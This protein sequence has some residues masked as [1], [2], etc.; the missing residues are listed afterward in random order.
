VTPPITTTIEGEALMRRSARRLLGAIATVLAATTTTGLITNAPVARATTG[1]FSS[2]HGI[3]VI[4]QQQVDPRRIDLTVS[5]SAAAGE[6]HIK[7]LL[8]SDYAT[9]SAARYP[10]LYLLHGAGD[11]ADA[12]L[13]GSGGGQA[14]AITAGKPLITVIP[15]GG[16]KGWYTNWRNPR[17]SAPQNWETFHVNQL[18]P[19]ID[20]NLRTIADR[21]GRAI[22]GLSM[23]GF[24]AMHYAIDHP[25][26]FAYVASFSGALDLL[27]PVIR[28]TIVAEELGAPGFGTPVDADAIF[29]LP[30]AGQD[31][32]WNAQSPA[33]HGAALRGM[34]IAIYT[35]DGNLLANPGGGIVESQVRPTAIL[36]HNNLD[37]A[38]IPNFF[39]DYG[40]GAGFG[41]YACDG[42]HDFGC[43]NDD[44]ADVLPRMLA[45]LQHP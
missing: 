21:Q 14:S 19:F 41:P 13:R 17:G 36:M 12:W 32:A 31:G 40:N 9:D 38:N 35:G 3:T 39:D 18:I 44:L 2:G 15:D 6:Q 34:G 23:G 10:V 42:N 5:T 7:I 29:G 43:W 28:A 11:T 8:P 25:G 30:V 16:L 1:T 33:Q 4:D 27:N 26:T 37:A 20:A 24:G 22:A 45:T